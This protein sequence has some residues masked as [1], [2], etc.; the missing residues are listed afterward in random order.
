MNKI[1]LSNI[2]AQKFEGFIFKPKGAEL[3]AYHPITGDYIVIDDGMCYSEENSFWIY[4]QYRFYNKV[5]G[6][7][8]F[9]SKYKHPFFFNKESS[10]GKRIGE[11]KIYAKEL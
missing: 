6:L 8:F 11:F 5:D 10:E 9:M 2:L 1:L 3:C 7:N 4:I